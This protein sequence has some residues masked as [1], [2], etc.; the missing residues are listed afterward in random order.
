M[1]IVFTNGCFDIVHTGHVQFLQR[2]RALGDLLIVGVNTDWSVSQLKGDSRPV[3][4]LADR[5]AVLRAIRWV[6]AVIP[7]AELTP[8]KLV[9]GIQPAVLVKGPGYSREN[10]PEAAGIDAWGGEVVILDGPDVST[11]K[12]LERMGDA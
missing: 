2:A 10:M 5:M 3:N 1:K 9:R 6:D 4:K 8:E 7:F 12:I 11:T